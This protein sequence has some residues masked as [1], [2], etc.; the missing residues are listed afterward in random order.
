MTK[1]Y[2]NFNEFELGFLTEENGKFVW[3]PSADQIKQFMVVYDG[4]ADLFL[5]D[6]T[7]PKAYSMVPYH[8]NEFLEASER[9]DL[10][11]LAKINPSDSD[12]LKLYKMATLDYLDQQFVIK[13]K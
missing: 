2:L 1:I 9:D 8:Y 12:F 5:L 11:K 6:K 13:V 10:A 3:T 7:Q 4:A